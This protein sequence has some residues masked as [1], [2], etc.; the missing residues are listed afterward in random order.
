MRGWLRPAAAALLVVLVTAWVLAGVAYNRRAPAE[1]TVR[2][3][4]REASLGWE[5]KEDTGMSLTLR[6]RYEGDD[7]NG[8]GLDQAR[9]REVGFQFPVPLDDP[10]AE[11]LYRDFLPR[12]AYAVLEMEGKAWQAHLARQESE[13]VKLRDEIRRGKATLEAEDQLLKSQA[14]D[15]LENSRLFVIDVGRD[16]SAL[17][18]NH[19]DQARFIVVPVLVRA[20]YEKQVWKS[21]NE[22]PGGPR[23]SGTVEL[24]NSSLHIPRA[25]RAVL[26]QVRHEDEA[27]RLQE[28]RK[29]PAGSL[30][31]VLSARP[32]AYEVLIR[33]GRRLEP[34][35]ESID[36]L[37]G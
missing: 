32:P 15:R 17:R 33:F 2:L 19:P 5:E 20:E 1:A 3:T 16:P 12:R 30:V 8:G 22:P 7:S 6:W 27:R 11:T 14:D 35:V 37:P 18:R 9:L 21:A 26:D 4:E 10:R 28:T 36:R 34:W 31:S 29:G 23:I 25:R 24:L 13:L